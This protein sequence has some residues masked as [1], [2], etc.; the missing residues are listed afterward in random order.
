MKFIIPLSIL[1]G[2]KCCETKDGSG[3][4]IEGLEVASYR[5]IIC[6]WTYSWVE[7]HLQNFIAVSGIQ[8]TFNFE[9]TSKEYHRHK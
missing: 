7:S 6:N 1:L 5:K 9:I 8:I 2:Q 3:T 4:L